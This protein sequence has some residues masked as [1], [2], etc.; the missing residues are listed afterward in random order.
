M[1]KRIRR[2]KKVSR[3]IIPM[4]I[5]TSP[6]GGETVYEQLPN[7][8]RKLVEQSQK[9]KDQ[10]MAYEELEMV[11]TEAIQLRRKYPTLQK[12]WDKYRTVWHL[13]NEN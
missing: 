11:G 2:K 4:P 8:E 9:A 7:G 6:D 10:Q 13:I 5:Y 3:K 1:A 12:A